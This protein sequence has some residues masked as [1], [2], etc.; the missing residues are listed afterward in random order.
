[1]P[2]QILRNATDV[3]DFVRGCTFMGTGGGGQPEDGLR[4]L[5]TLLD[6]GTTI[7]WVDPAAI[8]DD[9][10]T[11]CPFLM[12]SIAPV[13]E[14]TQRR[15]KLFGLTERVYDQRQVLAEAMKALAAFKGVKLTA[16]V[17][18]ELGGANT[19]GGLAAG[20]S[21]GLSVVDGDYTGRA[22][23]EA[24]Q[25]TPYLAEKPMWPITSVDEWGNV[26]VLMDAANYLIAER[27]GKFLSAAAFGL[28]GDAGFLLPGRDMKR[29]VVRGTLTRCLTIG[30]AIREAREKGKDPVEEVAKLLGGWILLRGRVAK[31]EWEDR[32]GYY[33]G[34]HTFAGEGDYAGQEIKIWFKNENHVSWKNGKPFVTSP[35]SLNVVDDNTGEPI[36]NTR[37]VEGRKVAVVALKAVPEF[38][39][40]RGL[41]I[42]GPRY[43]GYDIDYTPAEKILGKPKG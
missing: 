43:F 37:I 7:K 18:I 17:P 1:M 13:T 33:W 15:I 41:G 36:T 30:R 32:D 4:S 6:Q 28:T 11:I 19:P 23:P 35:D 40:P 24:Q 9:A 25:T 5:K 39:T 2:E 26:A 31:K 20:L 22:I 42:L 27:I 8:P 10:W 34:L 3:E 12:G 29:I 21:L 16:V 38:R 14:E